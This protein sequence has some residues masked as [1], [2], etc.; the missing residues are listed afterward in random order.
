MGNLVKLLTLRE[1]KNGSMQDIVVFS[2]KPPYH[3]STDIHMFLD[4]VEQRHLSLI[5]NCLRSKRR[6][7]LTC[8]NRETIKSI[9]K[10]LSETLDH[11]IVVTRNLYTKNL[12]SRFILMEG[13]ALA[14]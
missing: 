14:N 9:C 11:E 5:V 7:W 3:F 12:Q 1:M 13:E 4:H 6:I 8:T 2:S 10:M